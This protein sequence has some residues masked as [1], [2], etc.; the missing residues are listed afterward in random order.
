MKVEHL[1]VGDWVKY[2]PTG[3]LIRIAGLIK[4]SV[5]FNTIYAY[6]GTYNQLQSISSAYIEPISLTEE[7]L[8]KNGFRKK[9]FKGHDVLMIFNL[10]ISIEKVKDGWLINT[11]KANED[12]T[13]EFLG[14][15]N[16]IHEIQHVLF[17][18]G[19]EK[20]VIL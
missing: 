18:S 8:L 20:E 3:R 5:G 1:M 7:L 17:V 14:I 11:A 10:G 9:K 16:Y 12:F 19:I 4:H 15:I 6:T 2:T 13:T